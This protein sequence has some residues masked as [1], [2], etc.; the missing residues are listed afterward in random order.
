MTPEILELT[1]EQPVA[2]LVWVHRDSLSANAWNP[3]IQ[4]PPETKLLKLSI[5]ENG[6][7]QPLVAHEVTD[8]Q[9]FTASLE[10]VD[11]YHRWLVSADP[12]VFALTNGWVPVVLLR[13]GTDPATA[14]MATV[15][16]NRARGTHHVLRMAD[17]VAE[18]AV[19]LAVEPASLGR[20]L[21]MDDEEVSRLLDRGQMTKRGSAPDFGQ[22]WIP[23]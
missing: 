18:L 21:G 1:R 13:T 16:H 5:L 10:I 9:G 3:N 23:Q 17:L 20:R 14:R 8:D 11:G 2:H 15:R 6:W 19:E 7:T 22:G 4:A 12:E